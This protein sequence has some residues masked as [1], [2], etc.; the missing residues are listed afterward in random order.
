MKKIIATQ[1]DLARRKETAAEIRAFLDHAAAFGYNTVVFYLEDRIK[2]ASYPYA[3]DE[4]SY[5]PDEMREL[6]RYAETLGIDIIPA[7][8]S[9]SHC[10][11]FL[12]HEEL[13]PMAELYGSI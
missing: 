10:E 13:L 3:S 8:S 9:H 6:V 12:S 1:I 4:E 7:V 11:R 2:T 5:T